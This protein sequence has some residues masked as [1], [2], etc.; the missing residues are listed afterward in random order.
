MSIRAN[1]VKLR[2]VAEITQEELAVIADVSR[3]AVSLW[4]IG[5]SEPRMGA[6]QRIADHF[7]IRKANIIEEG[8]MDGAYLSFDGTIK[9]ASPLT[10]SGLSQEE[11]E[12]VNLFRSCDNIM[13]DAI[14]TLARRYAKGN[15]IQKA[16]NH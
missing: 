10:N 8:G 15:S 6:I 5:K 12:L 2:E 14:M 16:V 13:R 11:V 1:V 9:F 3:A 7:H 4:E